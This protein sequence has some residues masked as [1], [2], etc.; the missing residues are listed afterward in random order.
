MAIAAVPRN[1]VPTSA[2]FTDPVQDSQAVFRRV[3]ETMARPGSIQNLPPL[4]TG[5]GRLGPAAAAICLALVDFETPLWLD[6]IL[7]AS[8]S[9]DFLRFHC[10]ARIVNDSQ[11]ADFGV[12]VGIP[13]SLST[14]NTGSDAYPESGTTL[15]IQVATLSEAGSLILSGPGIDSRREI[16]IDGIAPAFWPAREAIVRG[17][18]RGLDLIFT[19][20]QRIA[21]IPR[22]TAVTVTQAIA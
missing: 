17:F 3:L 5:S 21:A 1:V 20:G 11:A 8:E 14:F 9:A 19:A 22:T 7:A 16:G 10:S 15:I 12:I 6:P 13:P 2:G 18:P 4:V